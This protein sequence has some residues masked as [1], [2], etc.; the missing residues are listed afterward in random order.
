[1]MVFVDICPYEDNL[2]P[3]RPSVLICK[4]GKIIVYIFPVAMAIEALSSISAQSMLFVIIVTIIV[5]V[6]SHWPSEFSQRR[7]PVKR[8]YCTHPLNV[9]Y[10]IDCIHP[11][12]R[13]GSQ[14]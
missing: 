13:T 3:L 6:V 12:K 11:V 4:T 2:T 14:M 10:R 5:I 9:L 7:H 1:M 8:M